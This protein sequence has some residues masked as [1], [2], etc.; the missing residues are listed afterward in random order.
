MARSVPVIRP[1]PTPW[2]HSSRAARRPA[3]AIAGL[4]LP[5]G[6]AP[7]EEQLRAAT[8]EAT[9]DVFTKENGGP[10]HPR[11]LSRLLGKIS[12][13]VGLPRLTADGLRHTSATLMLASGVPPKV[14]AERL[15]HADTRLF[16]NPYSHVTP[17][18]LAAKID[19]VLQPTLR[20]PFGQRRL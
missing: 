13:G 2:N 1:R 5:V 4:G 3:G 18:I 6:E 11:Y 20:A 10:H 15:G 14:A 8:Y 17:T 7:G 16:S 19:H 12:T 9:Y